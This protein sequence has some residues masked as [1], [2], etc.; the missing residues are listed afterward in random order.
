MLLAVLIQDLKSRSVYWFWFPLL[1][2][3]LAMLRLRTQPIYEVLH[4][5]MANW[6]FV[7]VQLL[8]VSLY[9]SIKNGRITNITNSLLGWG[10]ILFL[11]TAATYLSTLNYVLFYVLSLMAVV[12]LWLPFL[13]LLRKKHGQIPLAGLQ[14]LLFVVCLVA[15][16]SLPRIDL[17]H[18]DWLMRYLQ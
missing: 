12:L 7:A 18:D 9:F 8:F 2:M 14:S 13:L 6:A 17:M 4:S 11:L 5:L 1:A 16:W 10:D 15:D 3:L